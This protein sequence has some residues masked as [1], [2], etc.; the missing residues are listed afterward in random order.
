VN[1]PSASSFAPIAVLCAGILLSAC[2]TTATGAGATMTQA[3]P[4]P[5][6][7]ASAGLSPGERLT[8]AVE[9]LKHNHRDQ[10]RL[11]LEAIQVSAPR[12][13]AGARLL[14]DMDADPKASLG[15]QHFAYT[16]RAGD[17]MEGLAERFLGDRLR[18]Y[19]LAR[20]NNINA[21]ADI[22]PGQVLMIPGV[23]HRPAPPLTPRVTPAAPEAP[24]VVASDPGRAKSL[25]A[26]A[27]EAL[28]RGQVGRSVR[29]LQQAAALDPT[30]ALIRR[31]LARAERLQAGVRR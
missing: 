5:V 12:E 27:L 14:R 21:P 4:P 30:S 23:F 10:A 29:L 20:Y 22:A 13:A 1:G 18:F 3:P 2:T 31:D 17:T 15:E 28:N 25:R 7:G 16:V 9:L 24:P 6:R 19:L 8:L 26:A 11:E